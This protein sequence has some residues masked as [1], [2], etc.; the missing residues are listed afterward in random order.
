MSRASNSPRDSGTGLLNRVLSNIVTGALFGF[1]I[2]MMFSVYVSLLYVVRGSAPFERL[3]VSV[4]SV[5]V[6]YLLGGIAIG[7][8]VGL[9]L[10]LAKS[11]LGAVLVGSV[12]GTATFVFA[13]VSIYGFTSWSGVAALL[14][15][16][17][18]VLVGSSCGLVYRQ[19]F[20]SD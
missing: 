2:G 18:G 17:W 12:A 7:S 8:L 6:F 4:L 20:G 3:E 9:L 14:A 19:L 16:T 5:V 13:L 15:V 10:P 11:R 1:S